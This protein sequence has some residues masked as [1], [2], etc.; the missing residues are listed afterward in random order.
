MVYVRQY[1]QRSPASFIRAS[2]NNLLNIALPC[3]TSIE[4]NNVLQS[5]MHSAGIYLLI[6]VFTSIA[7]RQM[8]WQF[9]WW[10]TCIVKEWYKDWG[11]CSRWTQMTVRS[12]SEVINKTDKKKK[13][14]GEHTQL[15]DRWEEAMVVRLQMKHCH[16]DCA[17]LPQVALRQSI[18]LCRYLTS[19]RADSLWSLVSAMLHFT[20]RWFHRNAAWSSEGCMYSLHTPTYAAR[21]PY[22]LVHMYKWT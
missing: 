9:M 10:R 3:H 6:F 5:R 8:V 17:N 14:I 4:W 22:P 15:T 2:V 13:W 1:L 12:Y 21:S 20:R 18:F 7:F 19:R 11:S 16:N